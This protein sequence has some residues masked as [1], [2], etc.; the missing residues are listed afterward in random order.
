MEEETIIEETQEVQDWQPETEAF[1]P[2]ESLRSEIQSLK[3]QLA[4]Q[5][6]SYTDQFKQELT[7]D[8]YNQISPLLDE[9]RKPAA[10]QRL[11]NSV[12]KGLGE[13][14][15]AYIED[16]ISSQPLTSQMIDTLRTKDPASLKILRNA[17]EFVD[18]KSKKQS[19]LA[20]TSEGS[21]QREEID[22]DAD[23][24]IAT[25]AKVLASQFGI[26]IEEAKKNLKENYKNYAKWK[27]TKNGDT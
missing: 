25:Q 3:Y 19:R 2:Y 8:I 27:T 6:V 12:G 15:K 1:D 10:V 5:E 26:S 23:R 13:E 22:V 4:N 20:P 9:V 18:A 14:A 17:A 7:G 16:Y 11:V 24:E 21:T